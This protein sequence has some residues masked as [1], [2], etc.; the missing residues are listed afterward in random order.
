MIDSFTE[1]S[2]KPAPACRDITTNFNDLSGV[3]NGTDYKG[4]STAADWTREYSGE[5]RGG[6]SEG[7]ARGRANPGSG[8]T[9][10]GALER[11]RG[12]ACGEKLKQTC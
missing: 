1:T 3:V 4:N 6:R 9:P 11:S 10:S 7:E 8:E 5:A 12:R 2:C